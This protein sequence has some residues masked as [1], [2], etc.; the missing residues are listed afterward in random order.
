[1]K[2]FILLI[3]S[4]LV[5]YSCKNELIC[6]DKLK[7]TYKIGLE[8]VFSY[9]YMDHLEKKQIFK[10]SPPFYPIYNDSTNSDDF[11][12]ELI[13]PRD[14]NAMR[15]F[16]LKILS[17]TIN[18]GQIPIMYQYFQSNKKCAEEATGLLQENG[19]IWLHPP[20]TKGFR[21]LEINPFPEVRCLL[22]KGNTWEANILVGDQWGD[23][24]WKLWNGN[25]EFQILY[26]ITGKTNLDTKLG[27]LTCYV[28]EAVST[29]TIGKTSAVFYFNEDHGFVK[30]VY[31]NINNSKLVIELQEIK[32]IPTEKFIGHY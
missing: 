10:F 14:E 22:K 7:D 15:L 2:Y 17:G 24:R 25:M 3:I 23:E 29:S 13:D 1:M 30:F 11:N 27:F 4:V 26:T 6:E 8:Y 9:Y 32:P 16:S 28:I 12:W 18:T 19:K 31:Q 21:I 5:M 20:R